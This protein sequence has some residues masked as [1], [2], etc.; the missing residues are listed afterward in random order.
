[1]PNLISDQFQQFQSFEASV[2]GDT[3][4]ITAKTTFPWDVNDKTDVFWKPIN[5]QGDRWDKLYPYRLLV[6]DITK[7]NE[8]YGGEVFKS[9]TSKISDGQVTYISQFIQMGSSWEFRLPISPQQ[10]QITDQ[11]AINTTA[12]MRGINEEHNGVVFKQISASGTTGVWPQRPS[13]GGLPKGKSS[14]ESIFSGTISAFGGLLD[15]ASDVA[16]AFSGSHPE[17][18]TDAKKPEETT[19]S[20]ES[21]GYF[22]AMMM[23]QFIERYTIEKKKS[24]NKNLRLVFDMPKQNKSFIVTP[25]SFSLKQSEQKPMEHLWA[26][27][28]QAWKRIE[29]D[30]PAPALTELPKAISANVFER[31]I[32]TLGAVRRLLGDA[33]DLVKAVRSDFQKVFN[34]LRQTA[35]AIK[36]LAGLV[37]AI[38]DLPRNIIEDAKSA[39]ESALFDAKNAFSRERIDGDSAGGSGNVMPSAI[40]LKS[41][42]SAAKA[43]SAINSIVSRNKANEG[44]SSQAIKDGAL[45]V[46]AAEQQQ[47]DPLET[48]FQNPEENFDLFDGINLD[49]VTMS[50]P[51]QEAIDKELEIVRLIDVEQLREFKEEILSLS[52]DISN[53]YGAGSSVFAEVY[54]RDVPNTR[55][56]P[57]TLEENEVLVG[58]MEVVQIYDLLTSTKEYDDQKIESPLE[59]VGG[60]ANE[61]G[62]AFDSVENKILVPVPFGLTIEEIAAR[63]LKDS[64]KF[65][66]IAT[67]NNLRSPY[68]DEDGFVYKLLSN[69]DGRQFNVDDSEARLYVGQKLTFSSSTAP[70]FIRRVISVEQIDD[71]NYLVTVDGVDDLA[72]LTTADGAQMQGYLPGTVNSQNQLYIPTTAP[73]DPDDRVKEISHLDEKQ[74]TK[75]SKVDF[76][77]TESGDLALNSVGDIR[78]SNGL[79]NLV[80]SL[81][82]KI[83]TKQGTLLRHLNYGLGLKHGVS[84][85]DIDNGAI[86]VELNKMIADDPR[87]DAI[88]RIDLKLAGSTLS[89]GMAVSI[90]NQTG[91][92]P[93][94]F[95]I[96]L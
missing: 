15:S 6:I 8:I 39:I 3:S 47:T 71:T 61:A 64:N 45:G 83:E 66:E 2:Q 29:L 32:N 42:R 17:Q 46:D 28:L 75:L 13:I 56:T 19:P 50:A 76:L 82:L 9:K 4:T 34:I 25:K 58:L 93:V 81:K 72:K 48:I 53:N 30:A 31:I 44:L 78:L 21:T 87:F 59:F 86:I 7:P 52:L 77:L 24:K 22:Q 94:S 27:Q 12:T 95:N 18:A 79:T 91:V 69:A 43:G 65:L 85:A 80:Q 33:M 54:G 74:L 51:Q 20:I 49:D 35:L 89:I 70:S 68:I 96:K 41:Q 14:L 1:M 92:V 60:L 10:L 57:M 73:A 36:D 37:F 90:A 23:G 38:A 55:V 62:I 16:S 88:T 26:F 40:A 11:Y 84:V 67:L 63:Y 5:I